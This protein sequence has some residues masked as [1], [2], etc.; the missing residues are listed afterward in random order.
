MSTDPDTAVADISTEGLSGKRLRAEAEAAMAA[1][2]P[3]AQPAVDLIGEGCQ[4][5]V[6]VP[7]GYGT[8]TVFRVMIQDLW[9][10]GPADSLSDWLSI[11][12]TIRSLNEVPVP[13]IA[14]AL[15]REPEARLRYTI[16]ADNHGT[17]YLTCDA[18]IPGAAVTPELLAEV[19]TAQRDRALRGLSL[20]EEAEDDD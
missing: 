2:F 12:W 10:T 9:L 5:D 19:L 20:L 14:D 15:L 6:V 11:R 8:P 16:T 3:D 1:C 13:R 18:L 7:D 4:A 17:D